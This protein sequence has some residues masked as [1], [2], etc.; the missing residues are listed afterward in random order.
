MKAA[1]LSR[2]HRYDIIWAM[3]ANQAG[4]GAL[5]FKLA[6]PKLPYFLEL[7]DGR[8]FEDM[9][10]RQPVLRVLW[11]LYR[12]IYLCA[13]LVKTI[14]NYIAKEVRGIGYR[15]RVEVIPNAVDVAKFSTAVPEEK[16]RTLA[17]RFG[18]EQSDVFLFTASRLV[19]SRGV[20]DVIQSLEFLPANVKLL[21]AG[22]GEDRGKL[23][24]VARG[25]EVQDRVIFAGHVSH[26][27]LPAYLKISDI[28]V[29]P[30]LI[31]GLGNSF[32]EAMAAG[33][34]IIGTRVGGIPDFLTEGETGLFCEVQD[35][36]SVAHAA[37][38]YI[39]GPALMR[40]VIANAS[41]LVAENYDWRMIA[42]DMKTKVFEPLT[43]RG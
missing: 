5:F 16:L 42:T 33:V 12:Q 35:P 27:E 23:E 25:L 36:R 39:D 11:S 10:T 3:M 7:Q 31:E 38:R 37:K 4:F 17:A 24:H 22:D 13:D 19:L 34:P 26:D 9:K 41:K 20:E 1:M 14:S 8:A 18:K 40:R 15:G 6:N 43:K 30:S 32:L 2:E 28:F 21:I 29:R